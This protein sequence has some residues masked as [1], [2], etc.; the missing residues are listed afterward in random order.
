MAG[1]VDLSSFNFRCISPT[2][3][4]RAKIF[5]FSLLGAMPTGT[6]EKE[7]K[8]PKTLNY[9]GFQPLSSSGK[10]SCLVVDSD[11]RDRLKIRSRRR[12]GGSSPFS[13]I[14]YPIGRPSGLSMGI[15]IFSE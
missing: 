2:S 15:I 6:G 10:F 12:G 14:V 7:K 8:R 1:K 9:Q 11:V 3:L 4:Q 13:G 5:S